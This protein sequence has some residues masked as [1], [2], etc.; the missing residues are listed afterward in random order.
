M[1]AQRRSVRRTV[2]AVTVAVA[3]LTL[4]ACGGDDGHTKA[5]A[6]STARSG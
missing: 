2:L 6:G 4:T 5:V 1:T 3:A